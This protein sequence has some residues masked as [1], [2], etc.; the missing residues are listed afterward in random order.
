MNGVF[1]E[2]TMTV[3][4]TTNIKKG[5]FE[6]SIALKQVKMLYANQN[7]NITL[8]FTDLPDD[9][10]FTFFYFASSEDP[11]ITAETTTVSRFNAKTLKALTININWNSHMLWSLVGLLCLMLLI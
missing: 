8:E 7:Y 6:T 4:T 3:P 10:E 1:N 2:N 9:T 5:L 11:T